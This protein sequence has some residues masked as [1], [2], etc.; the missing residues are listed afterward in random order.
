MMKTLRSKLL[1]FFMTITFF[2]LFV[3]AFVSYNS[4]KEAMETQLERSFQLYAQGLISSVHDIIDE[5]SRDVGYLSANP[6]LKNPDASPEEIKEQLGEFVSYFPI[7][8]HVVLLDPDG[9]VVADMAD[10]RYIGHNV[11]EREWFV[12]A[13]N[14][15][16]NF[17]EIYYSPLLEK[18]VSVIA[19]PVTD[20]AGNLVGIL[21]PYYD[22]VHL[23][24]YVYAFS[25][26]Q[27]E[28]GNHAYAFLI[29]EQGDVIGHPD[30][31][32]ILTRNYLRDFNLSESVLPQL[33][34]M[35]GLFFNDQNGEVGMVRQIPHTGMFTHNWYLGVAVPEAELLSPLKNLLAQYLM[36]FLFI[37]AAMWLA[38][39]HFSN[40]LVSPV[41]RLLKAQ[42]E[43]A[44]GY[45]P[46]PVPV[47]SYQE[48]NQLSSEFNVTMAK[49]V[50]RENIHKK[51]T[52]ILEAT[53]N[54]VFAVNTATLEITTFNKKCESMFGKNRSDV[55]GATVKDLSESSEAF[56]SV[57]EHSGL[58]KYLEAE[59]RLDD[60]EFTCPIDGEERY[61]YILFNQLPASENEDR[62]E[63]LVII[64]D[65]TENRMMLKQ[66]IQSEKV[67]AAGE[68]AASFAH[69]IRNP[70]TTIRGFIQ[71]MEARG[72][73]EQGNSRNYYQIILQEI[74]RINGIVGDLMNLVRPNGDTQLMEADVNELLEDITLLYDG[75]VSSSKVTIEKDLDENVPLF[76]TFGSKLKQ[77]FINIIKNAFE[78]MPDGGSLTIRT[79]YNVN[80]ET[81]D[82]IFTDTGSGMDAYTL[83]NLRKPF[84]TTKETGT[85]LGMPTCYMIIEELG[86]EIKVES[87]PGKGTVFTVR[88]PVGLKDSGL[89]GA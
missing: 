69:E 53:D 80:R 76:L 10:G 50:E 20:N 46:D 7:F 71:L 12:R 45:K 38:I 85:G 86:G 70:L 8:E 67:K 74:D 54:A 15:E 60:F 82:I 36:I 56:R 1:L 25:E 79:S 44:E 18:P 24:D 62:K 30:E 59:Q 42:A 28:I 14:G 77:V 3:I 39:I 78:A 66:L 6:V 40:Y 75:Q 57:D 27:K 35:D 83:E 84:F 19:V 81:V 23:W 4:Q 32:Q 43:F 73:G 55:I 51:S 16:A 64:T 5:V 31:E 2:S 37:L 41:E 65:V 89:K 63:I 52:M 26:L 72:I 22:L 11:S 88:L 29:N 68:L 33:A 58:I 13:L 61:L 21:S 17:A 87:E 34:A 48:I 49:A 47:D 9:T